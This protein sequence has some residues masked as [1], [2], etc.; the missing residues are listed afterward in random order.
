MQIFLLK[1]VNHYKDYAKNRKITIKSIYLRTKQP[2]SIQFM[3]PTTYKVEYE[4]EAGYLEVNKVKAPLTLVERSAFNSKIHVTPGYTIKEIYVNNEKTYDKNNPLSSQKGFTIHYNPDEGI[5]Y[6]E[7]EYISCNLKIK[8]IFEECSEKTRKLAKII[9]SYSINK[10]Y[11]DPSDT[12]ISVEK[13][14]V[15]DGHGR[16]VQTQVPIAEGKFKVSAVYLDDYGNVDYAPLPYVSK[17][18]EYEYEDMFCQKCITKSKAYYNGDVKSSKERVDSYG[19]PYNRTNYHYG[20]N[21]A[22]ISTEAGMG[23][24]SFELGKNFAKTWRIPA[25]TKNME[26]FFSIS[27]LKKMFNGDINSFGDYFDN[28]L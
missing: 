15:K 3:S 1:K 24:A 21:G 19:F 8:V 16:I 18:D 5:A 2:R 20:E 11:V 25:A 12:N 17:K 14:S 10:I 4:G 7:S 9:P 22:L 28:I 23:E 26:E 13:Y 6:L 27:Q